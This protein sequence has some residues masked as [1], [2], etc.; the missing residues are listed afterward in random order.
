MVSDCEERV[1]TVPWERLPRQ[2][3]LGLGLRAGKTERSQYSNGSDDA[4][5]T[6]AAISAK[7]KTSA[8]GEGGESAEV[9]V[10]AS[11]SP[12]HSMNDSSLRRD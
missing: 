11:G 12:R 1:L 10:G 3:L 8:G 5:T 2:P 6:E 7:K 4:M 9:S